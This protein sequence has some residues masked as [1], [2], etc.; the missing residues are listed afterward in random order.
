MLLDGAH[1][2]QEACR[3]GIGLNTVAFEERFLDR[4]EGAALAA[5]LQASGA[6]LVQVTSAVM[7]AMSPVNA[8][9]GVVAVAHRPVPSPDGFL[10]HAPQLGLVAV[11]VQDPGNAGAMGRAAEAAG[12]TGLAFCGASAD[13]YGW[14]ALRGSMGSLLRMPVAA[15]LSWEEAIEAA[16]AAGVRLLATVPRDAPP[17]YDLDLRGPVAFL[18][19]GEGPGLPE[20]A[21]A[22]C[23]GRVS[24]PMCAPVESLNV[25][26]AAALMAYE[27]ARQRRF[28]P[29]A[30]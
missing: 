22:V 20:E 12:A 29:P 1:L 17:L 7:E 8:P 13:P 11:D 4:A 16:R 25:S 27:A 15:G 28:Q 2:L 5:A 18:L 23:D 9:S 3:S 30:P 19:G 10:G 6:E 26:V 24:I 14:K 21:I